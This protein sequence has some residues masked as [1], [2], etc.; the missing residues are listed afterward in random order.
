MYEDKKNNNF[1][2]LEVFRWQYAPRIQNEGR[3]L[4]LSAIC[5]PVRVMQICPTDSFSKE[6]QWRFQCNISLSC[7]N[8]SVT[9]SESKR[10]WCKDK[11][12]NFV[13]ATSRSTLSRKEVLYVFNVQS[14]CRKYHSAPHVAVLSVVTVE[15]MDIIN[16]RDWTKPRMN[17]DVNERQQ[18]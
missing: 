14:E 3:A 4:L 7:V 12:V 1:H 17:R 10:E 2:R 11:F 6:G 16:C 13:D 18:V 9:L 8:L 15:L 5:Q